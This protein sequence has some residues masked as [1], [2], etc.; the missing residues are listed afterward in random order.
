MTFIIADRTVTLTP[1]MWAHWLNRSHA[2]DLC[3]TCRD[4]RACVHAAQ[5]AAA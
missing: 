3:S 4:V 1:A 5:K 2:I